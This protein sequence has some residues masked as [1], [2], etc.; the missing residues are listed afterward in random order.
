[1]SETPTAAAQS[2]SP[3]GPPTGGESMPPYLTALRSVFLVSMHHGCPVQPEVLTTG[4]PGDALGTVL[5]IMRQAGLKGGVIEAKGFKDLAAL[6]DAYPVIAIRKSGHYII[7]VRL[8]E[9]N[10]G[11]T[12]ALVLDPAVEASGM[13][14]LTEEQLTAQWDGR[15]ILCRKDQPVAEEPEKFGFRWFVPEIL[16]HRSYLRD[17]AIAAT[18]CNLIGFATPL[19]FH[20]IIDKVI[21]HQSYETLYIVVGVFLLAAVFE[22]VFSYIRQYLMLF[23]TNKIDASVASRTFKHLLGLPLHFFES[24]PAGVLARH[25]QQTDKI[26]HFLTGRLFQTLLDAAM[27]P[28]LLTLLAFYSWKL[29]LIVLGFSM[30]IAVVIGLMIPV[31]RFHLNQLYQAEGVRQA[32]LVETL[33]GMRTIKSLCL[34]PLKK[35]AWDNKVVAAVRRHATVGR[36]GALANVLTTGLDKTMQMAVIGIGALEVFDGRL[37]MGALVAFNMLSGRVSGPLLQIVGLINEYQETA[38]S[39]RMLGTVMDHAPERSVG[40]AGSRPPI[41]GDLEFDNVVFRYPGAASNALDSASFKVARGQVIG[42]VGRSGSGKT[43][44]TRLIQGIHNAQ[45]GVIRLGGVDIR[46]IDLAHLRRNVGVVL[47]DNFLFRGTIREN[48]AATKPDASLDEV[49]AAATL[50][51]ANEFIDRLPAS[52]D[53]MLEEGAT[54]LS[55]G[56]RQRIAIARA[57]VLRPKLL[58]FDEATSALD[59]ESEAIIQQN[60]GEIARGRTMVIVSHRLSS[61]V[62]ADSILVLDRGKVADFAP[63]DVLVQRCAIYAHLWHQQTQ[64][65]HA[66]PRAERTGTGG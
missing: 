40:G 42:I 66:A 62:T 39:I 56:Q 9:D 50:A 35:T 30:L 11:R 6:G 34:E 45:D 60:L 24:I 21:P 36:L 41:D 3:T 53:T 7:I 26:R 18:V 1:M 17:V 19:L 44:V 64:H 43:T 63:H 65:V 15:L 13:A 38:L 14:F 49:A 61:L 31:F 4:D 48:I 25:M 32:H 22:G 51:G 2:P 52:Y 28:I 12:T 37:S 47:Q 10:E 23:A 54:N 58:I 33:H 59:P 20:V 46:Q 27:L 16:R 8:V 29:T 55:G 5:R 57:L